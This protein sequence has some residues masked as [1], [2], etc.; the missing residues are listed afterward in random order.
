MFF[1]G[2]LPVC[3]KKKFSL[4]LYDVGERDLATTDTQAFFGLGPSVGCILLDLPSRR[5]FFTEVVAT[6]LE[7][8]AAIFGSDT[9]EIFSQQFAILGRKNDIRDV[10]DVAASLISSSELSL[11]TIAVQ[12]SKVLLKQFSIPIIRR[13][14]FGRQKRGKNYI[15]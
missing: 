7:V 14:G 13:P 9:P 6:L 4:I 8:T 5:L 1:A 3:L 12:R 10:C 11:I 2:V 15:F